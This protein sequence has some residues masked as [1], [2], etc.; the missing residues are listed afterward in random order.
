[1]V[2][3]YFI[4]INIIRLPKFFIYGAAAARDE[5]KSNR[6]KGKVKYC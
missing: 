2:F 3:F 6:K 4:V 1:V 5:V